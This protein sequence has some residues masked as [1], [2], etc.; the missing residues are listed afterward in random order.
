MNSV[1]RARVSVGVLVTAL[2]APFVLAATA[3]VGG[4]ALGWASLAVVTVS[5]VIAVVALFDATRGTGRA[6]FYLGLTAAVALVAGLIYLAASAD[7]PS[8][9]PLAALPLMLYGLVALVVSVGMLP[10]KNV[11]D[12]HSWR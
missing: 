2:I 9:I 10:S 1:L 7:E 5:G 6:P 11:V 12:I 4:P 8:A 3:S